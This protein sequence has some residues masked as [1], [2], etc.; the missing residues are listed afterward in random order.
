MGMSIGPA[1]QPS[2]A[3]VSTRNEHHDDT[4]TLKSV[5]IA[6]KSNGKRK[7]GDRPEGRTDADG[8]GADGVTWGKFC[9]I[10]RRPSSRRSLY[11]LQKPERNGTEDGRSQPENE[12][13][14]FRM[15]T[16]TTHMKA[17]HATTLLSS[18]KDLF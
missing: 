11:P 16:H 14:A 18:T 12:E 10:F 6:V 5:I 2:H 9:P 15:E 3:H 8:R 7:I 4:A 1:P 17:C 13:N